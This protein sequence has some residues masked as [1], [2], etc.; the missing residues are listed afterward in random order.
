MILK[1]LF[2]EQ[3][4]TFTLTRHARLHDAA[5]L[6]QRE[7]IGS[8]VIVEDQKVIGIVTD[9]DIGLC[10]ALGAATPDSLVGEV[11]SKSV[12]TINESMN[13]LDVTM[14]FRTARV[15]RLPVVDDYDRLVGIISIDDVMALL[16]REMFDTCS[17]LE[18]KIGHMI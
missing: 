7:K 14:F 11:M 6:M 15:K 16:S 12:E 9:R 13:L 2:R 8:I 1:E 5:A 3:L 10:L 17:A 18:P 4:E